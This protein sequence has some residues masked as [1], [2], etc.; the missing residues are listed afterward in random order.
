[1]PVLPSHVLSGTTPAALGS[2]PFNK[3]PIGTGPFTFD[4][5]DPGRSVTLKANSRYYGGEP[6]ISQV[7]FLV[8][9]DS[10]V[11]EGALRDGRLMLAQL[12]PNDAEALLKSNKSMRG[13]AY[14]ELGYDFVA[15]NLRPTHVFS[16]TRLRQ[17]WALA[18]DKPGLAYQAT[19]GG[20]DPV[21]SDVNKA[22]W[23]YNPGVPRLGGNPEQARKLIADAGWVDQNKDGIV[24]KNGKPLEVVLYV[25]SN[26][27]VRRKAANAM[28]D[29]LRRVGIQLKVQIADFNTSLLGRLSPNSRPPFDFDAMILGWTRTGFDPDAFALFHSSQVPTPASPTLLNFTGFAAP[30]YDTLAL[31]ARSSYDYDARKDKYARMQEIIADQL[32]YYFL[33]AEKFG[34]VAGPKLHGDIDFASPR[35]LW[36]VEQWWIEP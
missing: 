33:W 2:S 1:M 8:A 10:G 9:P 20:G 11:A 36:N 5:R 15:F 3:A 22:S 24:E 27:A 23:A 35:Y 21:W 16:D 19:G 7:A 30:E 13:G 34:V 14:D 18:L 6:Y 31:D 17:A 25:P 29:P 26:N 12:P 4:K 28:V 32:P